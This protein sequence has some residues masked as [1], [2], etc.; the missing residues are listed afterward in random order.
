V[1]ASAPPDAGQ[2]IEALTRAVSP[3]A[4]IPDLSAPHELWVS[5]VL[6]ATSNS[7]S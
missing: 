4:T 1:P 7:A 6:S 5:P 2:R 3:F